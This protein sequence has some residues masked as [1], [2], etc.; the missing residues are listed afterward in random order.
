LIKSFYFVISHFSPLVLMF[1]KVENNI[2]KEY[3][4]KLVTIITHF[5]YL[6]IYVFFTQSFGRIVPVNAAVSEFFIG[7]S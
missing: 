7:F 1:P 6:S 2:L 5:G 4:L 3:V